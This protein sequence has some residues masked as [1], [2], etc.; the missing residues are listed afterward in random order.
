MRIL[1]IGGNG[2][3]GTPLVR[4]LRGSGHEV[5]IFHRGADPS[6]SAD[7]VAIRGDRNHLP[8]YREQIQQFSPDV[9]I[10]LILSSGDQAR[11]VM[12]VSRGLARRVVAISSMDVYRAWGVVTGSETGSLEPLPIT[13]DS[14]VRTNRNV[15]SPE[16]REMLRGVF[17]W[18]DEDYDKIAVEQIILNDPALAGTVLRLPMVY[19]PGDRLHRFFPLLKRIADGRSSILLADD[20]AAWLAPRGYVEN[21]AHAIA[22]AATLDQAAGRVYNV[23]D[24]PTLTELSWQEKIARQLLWPGTFVVLP[25]ERTPKH[26]LQPGN[27]TQHVVVSSERI[28]TELHYKEPVAIDEAIR[29]T[30]TWEQQNPPATIDPQ[31]FDYDAEDKALANQA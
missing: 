13:E 10:D 8:D 14:P 9:V 16:A 26:L 19:G 1:L 20:L 3:I 4:E 7:V 31:R 15:Y 24:E 12:D 29:R 25:R 21:V 28:R 27:A 18:F 30:A 17:S 23:C 6:I 22:L 5:A 11:Q 2:F